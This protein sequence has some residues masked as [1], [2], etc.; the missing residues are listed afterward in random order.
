VD[1]PSGF[2]RAINSTWENLPKFVV[3]AIV[4]LAVFVG[5]F[6]D[7]YRRLAF[8][9]D[10]IRSEQTKDR[11][12]ARLSDCALCQ[13]L[14]TTLADVNAAT[15]RAEDHIDSHNRESEEWKVRIRQLEQWR[16]EFSTK[17]A[18]RPDPFTGTMG[19]ELEARIHALELNK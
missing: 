1:E 2:K 16:Y 17:P 7:S 12:C 19:L 5:G 8:E 11:L 18:A 15:F 6:W 10:H 9:V 13:R 3:A 14:A 4:A